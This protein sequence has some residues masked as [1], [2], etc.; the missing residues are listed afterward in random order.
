MTFWSGYL[1]VIFQEKNQA[2]LLWLHAVI[3][4]AGQMHYGIWVVL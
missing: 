1:E 2:G 4:T 3:V